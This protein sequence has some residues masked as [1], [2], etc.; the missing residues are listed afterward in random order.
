MNNNTKAVK[1]KRRLYEVG[2][3]AWV[4]LLGYG[5]MLA[6]ASFDPTASIS[7]KAISRLFD[8]HIITSKH[9]HRYFPIHAINDGAVVFRDLS[10]RTPSVTFDFLDRAIKLFQKI[11]DFDKKNGFPGAR[12]V[13][14]CGFRVRMNNQ[15]IFQDHRKI[16]GIKEKLRN[17]LISADQAVSESISIRHNFGLIPELQANFAFTKAYL[18]EQG[19]SKEGFP[20]SNCFIDLSMFVKTIPDWISFEKQISWEK[21]GMKGMFGQFK[22]IDRVLAN[23][24]RHQGILDAFDIAENISIQD[25]ISNVLVKSTIKKIG[26]A[27]K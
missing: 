2:C 8:F 10:P 4:D 19:G 14:A 3:V 7:Q 6:D 15:E 11:N 21:M 1:G 23:S 5:S 12:M 18:V 17:G 9:A 24:S 20:G 25:N 27:N 16:K 22:S 26:S 13:I